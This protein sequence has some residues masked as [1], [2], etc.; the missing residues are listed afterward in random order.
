ME[1]GLSG[2]KWGLGYGVDENVVQK[3]RVE[4]DGMGWDGGGIGLSLTLA[5]SQAKNSDSLRW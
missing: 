2:T 1:V 4:R 3:L 5:I